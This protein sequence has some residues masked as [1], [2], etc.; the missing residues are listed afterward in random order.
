MYLELLSIKAL[1]M[2][3]CCLWLGPFANCYSDCSL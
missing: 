1:T 2:I 3:C